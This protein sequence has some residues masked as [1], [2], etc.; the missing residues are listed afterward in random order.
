MFSNHTEN[1][2]CR[3]KGVTMVNVKLED[4]SMKYERKYILDELELEIKH[5]ELLVLL[6][7]SG[8]GKTSLLKIVAGIIE[9]EKGKV[10]IDNLDVTHISP[11]KRKIGYVPQAQVLF[12]H[13]TVKENISF[14]L[15][16]RKLT[17]EET[18]EKIRW[19]VELT[20]LED[21]LERYPSE[22]SGGQKQKVALARAMAI[23]PLLLLLD[24]PLSSIDAMG[25]E[26]LAL[27]IRRIQKE[28]ETTAIYVTHNQEEARLT[29][30]RV[31][32]MYDSKIQQS[33]EVIT[34]DSSPR[35]YLIAKIMGTPNIWQVDFIEEEKSATILSTNLGKIRIPKKIERKVTGV[36]IPPSSLKISFATDEINQEEN[37]FYVKGRTKSVVQLDE[38]TDR[39]IV[40]IINNTI[41]Y[42]KV[43]VEKSLIT[44]SVSPNK[45][46]LLFVNPLE[47]KIL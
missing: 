15:E 6:G 18:E 17:K 41:E 46:V 28:T 44:T 13:M 2:R 23:E 29:S 7:E 9:P 38:N 4:I 10:W 27:T 1:R 25:R 8:C 31:G 3:T 26:E 20:H 45:E 47:I 21:L 32:I 19:V 40:E 33:G 34:I 22:L 42:A 11:Q 43:D 5:G 39:I 14:G 37:L 12:P 24:E 35:N 30:D 16:S 36:N